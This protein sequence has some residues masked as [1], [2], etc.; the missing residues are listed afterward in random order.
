[1]KAPACLVLTRHRYQTTI[2]SLRNSLIFSLANTSNNCHDLHTTSEC[3]V[4][5]RHHYHWKKQYSRLQVHWHNWVRWV[6]TCGSIS[7]GTESGKFRLHYFQRVL[8]VWTMTIVEIGTLS[9]LNKGTAVFKSQMTRGSMRMEEIP[10][11]SHS[12][13]IAKGDPPNIDTPPQH[14]PIVSESMCRVWS[15]LVQTVGGDR[16]QTHRHRISAF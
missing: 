9:P 13:Y 16:E 15:G 12:Q 14:S 11:T 5:E 6:G 3:P 8:H 10:Y 1:M 4:L 7:F 2:T